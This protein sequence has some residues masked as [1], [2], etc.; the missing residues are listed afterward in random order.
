[1]NFEQLSKTLNDS[2]NKLNDSKKELVNT[3]REI[4]YKYLCSFYSKAYLSGSPFYI[5]NSIKEYLDN[6]DYRLILVKDPKLI[7]LYYILDN[8]LYPTK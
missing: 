2:K 4:K 3:E 6:K 1:M 5:G 8:N 7:Y